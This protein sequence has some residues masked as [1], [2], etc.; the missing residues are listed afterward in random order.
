MK[1][2]LPLYGAAGGLFYGLEVT[3]KLGR[4]TVRGGGMGRADGLE[5]AALSS[6]VPSFDFQQEWAV[7]LEEYFRLV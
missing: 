6:S 1:K 4:G 3:E 7:L 5:C 2:G